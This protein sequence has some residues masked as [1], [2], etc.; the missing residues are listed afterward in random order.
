[1]LRLAPY[2]RNLVLLRDLCMWCSLAPQINLNVEH[3]R[4]LLGP[5]LLLLK[6]ALAIAVTTTMLFFARLQ[7][8]VLI[9]QR[10]TI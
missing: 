9:S 8:C 2:D 4:G 3:L 7:V 10:C 5:R 6:R 1:M